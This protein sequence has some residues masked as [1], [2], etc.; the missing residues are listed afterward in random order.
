MCFCYGHLF[1]ANGRSETD[2]EPESSCSPSLSTSSHLTSISMTTS[3]VDAHKLTAAADEPAS[4]SVSASQLP[5]VAVTMTTVSSASLAVDEPFKFETM[6]HSTSDDLFY[7]KKDA[8]DIVSALQGS[9]DFLQDSEI[10]EDSKWRLQPLAVFV[11]LF[12][13]I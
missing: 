13:V 8:Q 1:V 4:A 12:T 3:P 6:S 11:G 9:F 2:T 5:T 7:D 10:D